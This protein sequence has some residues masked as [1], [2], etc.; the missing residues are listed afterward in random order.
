MAKTKGALFSLD[1]WGS[2]GKTLIFQKN[3]AGSIVKIW[4]SSAKAPNESQAIIRGLVGEATRVWQ[5]MSEGEKAEYREQASG[6]KHTGFNRFVSEYVRGLY[7]AG[8]GVGCA[9]LGEAVLGS[10]ELGR[11]S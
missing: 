7:V 4:A 9:L 1:A 10:M 2:F 3:R 6:E 5:E 8:G 11:E